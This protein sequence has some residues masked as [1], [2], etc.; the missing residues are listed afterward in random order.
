MAIF[1]VGAFTII[2]AIIRLAVI[3]SEVL[4]YGPTFPD[5]TYPTVGYFVACMPTY[6]P[7]VKPLRRVREYVSLVGVSWT[8]SS[9]ASRKVTTKIEDSNADNFF[10]A[11]YKPA[12]TGDVTVARKYSSI[13]SRQ[14]LHP[15]PGT[16]IVK[17]DFTRE[18]HREDS[19]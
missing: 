17:K 3:S 4:E 13:N 5:V 18:D 7:L 6:S 9:N 8:R 12:G 16:V 19:W 15:V 10:L 11:N 1:A 14:E 2:I